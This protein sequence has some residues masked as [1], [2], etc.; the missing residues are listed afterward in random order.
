MFGS[1]RMLRAATHGVE[2]TPTHLIAR[3]YFFTRSY[4]RQEIVSVGAVRLTWWP[5]LLLNVLLNCDVEHT[6]RLS[7]IGGAHRVL[8]AANSHTQDVEV[9]VEIVR[10]WCQDDAT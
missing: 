3:G 4:R 8:L 1:R 5:S 7:L 10:A 9:A 6:L 2:L